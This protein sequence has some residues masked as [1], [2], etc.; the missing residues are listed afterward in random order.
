M[1]DITQASERTSATAEEVQLPLKLEVGLQVAARFNHVLGGTGLII[2]IVGFVVGSITLNES[3]RPMAA[4]GAILVLAWFV[5]L[6]LIH[7]V[8][9]FANDAIRTKR[10]IEKERGIQK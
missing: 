3:F 2:Y 10:K 7:F 1:S 6:I 9:A 5:F 8:R 4:A